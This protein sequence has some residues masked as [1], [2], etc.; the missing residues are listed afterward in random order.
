[1]PILDLFAGRNYGDVSVCVHKL[2]YIS[3]FEK[4]WNARKL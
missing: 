3:S 4:F 1:M 2:I